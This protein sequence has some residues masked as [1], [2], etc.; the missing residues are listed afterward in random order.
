LR[1]S[2]EAIPTRLTLGADQIDLA[3]AGGRAGTLAL[4]RLRSY[5]NKRVRVVP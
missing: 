1:E 3:I 2:I 4:P 5:L